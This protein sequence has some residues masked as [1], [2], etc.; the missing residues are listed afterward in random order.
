M[1]IGA[2]FACHMQ[3]F[4]LVGVLGLFVHLRVP[5]AI[6]GCL[7]TDAASP[8][9]Q[10]LCLLVRLRLLSGCWHAFAAS[11]CVGVLSGAPLLTVWLFCYVG[12][13]SRAVRMIVQGGTSQTI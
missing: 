8:T 2:V 6:C 3:L 9:V 10:L 7:L 11:L 4:L 5:L 1:L 12:V 13:S